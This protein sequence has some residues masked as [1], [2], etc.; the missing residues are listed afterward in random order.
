MVHEHLPKPRDSGATGSELILR[1]C[2]RRSKGG[3]ASEICFGR[4]ESALWKMDR[5]LLR[6]GATKGRHVGPSGF[7]RDWTMHM[8]TCKATSYRVCSRQLK[9]RKCKQEMQFGIR[10]S[11]TTKI[12][13]WNY[14]KPP[15]KTLS[16]SAGALTWFFSQGEASAIS[17]GLLR[18]LFFLFG[19]SA[20]RLTRQGV[21]PVGTAHRDF[22]IH[23]LRWKVKGSEKDPKTRQ[24]WAAPKKNSIFCKC[25]KSFPKKK[26]NENTLRKS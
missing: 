22:A 9:S 20:E 3:G 1:L 5:H 19:G 23:C 8:R 16:I 6:F 11:L 15:F 18:L 13:R 2:Q 21:R 17:L 14:Y 7:L 10:K 4:C 25:L 24:V 12:S 26:K